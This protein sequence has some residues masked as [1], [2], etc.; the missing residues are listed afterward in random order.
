MVTQ[1]GGLLAAE[2]GERRVRKGMIG[3][4]SGSAYSHERAS[5]KGGKGEGFTIKIVDCLGMAH[6]DEGGR[7]RESVSD[8]EYQFFGVLVCGVDIGGG[9]VI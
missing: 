6:K 2:V 8:I 4:F 3:S 9:S 7:H 5:S 1:L